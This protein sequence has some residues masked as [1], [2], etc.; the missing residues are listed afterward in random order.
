MSDCPPIHY[1]PSADGTS[2]AYWTLGNGPPLLLIHRRG[3]SHLR[4]EWE[5]PAM[6]RLYNGLARDFR[7]IRYD[8]RG[9][10]L[11]QAA[12][13]ISRDA[14]LGDIDAVL[15]ASRVTRVP[16]LTLAG[17]A[18]NLGAAYAAVVPHRVSALVLLSPCPPRFGRGVEVTVP[19]ELRGDVMGSFADPDGSAEDRAAIGRLLAT[20]IRAMRDLQH[21]GER[22]FW[23]EAE[24]DSYGRVSVPTLVVDWPDRFWSDGVPVVEA[25]AGARLVT[26]EG[27]GAPPMDPD[28]PSLLRLIRDFVEEYPALA[29]D[30]V[31]ACPPPS[32]LSPRE[33]EVVTL[34]AAG[35]PNPAIAEQLCISRSTVARHVSSALGKTGLSNRTQLA[36]YAARNGLG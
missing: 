7:L 12:T 20:G 16:I 15:D 22:E 6:R 35:L 13:G 23:E 24:D 4:L 10:G 26:R 5:V 31:A 33:R 3:V 30:Y 21:P 29:D 17:G 2:I 1:A 8:P 11:S 19:D 34:V 27:R 18:S 32:C 25:I 14:A 9:A 28:L 36:L